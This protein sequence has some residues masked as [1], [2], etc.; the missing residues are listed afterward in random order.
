[1]IFKISSRVCSPYAL[2]T[3]A[4]SNAFCRS[5]NYNDGNYATVHKPDRFHGADENP[6]DY[7][8]PR[9]GYQ[10][11]QQPAGQ[12]ERGILEKISI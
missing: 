7:V 12:I 5:Y 3:S 9:S 6:Y 10:R 4:F 11:Q 1:L 2:Y 8:A